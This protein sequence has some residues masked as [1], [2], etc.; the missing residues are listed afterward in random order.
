MNRLE[1]KRQLIHGS[2]FILALLIKEGY[3]LFGGWRVPTLSLAFAICIGYGLSYLHVKGVSLPILSKVIK[4]SER[5][6]DKEFPGRGAL[7]FFLGAFFTILIFRNHPEI[8]A[9]SII[10]LA[11]GDSLSTLVGVGYGR[12][13]LFYNKEKSVEGSIGGILAAF[14]GLILLTTFPPTIAAISS[15]VGLIT[16]SLPLDVDDNLTVPVLTGFSLWF[17]TTGIII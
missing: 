15:L 11:L 5:E 2:G 7:R 8:V 1:I 9:G 3:R 10:V 13:K 6:K 12:H 14:L 4:E 17:L 16:E